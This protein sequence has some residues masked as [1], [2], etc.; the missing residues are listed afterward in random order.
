MSMLRIRRRVAALAVLAAAGGCVE[1]EL[2][3]ESDPPGADVFVDGRPL[4]TTPFKAPFVFYGTREL[5]LRKEK[6]APVS[7]VVEIK[8]PWYQII[9][10]DLFFEHLWPGTLRDVREVR[11]T[12]PPLVEQDPD[13]LLERAKA[14]REEAKKP[15]EAK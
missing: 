10:L 7:Q 5:T 9:P 2:V 11:L 14:W 13:G 3:I 15:P 12:L 6:F 8:P 1:R 4:G